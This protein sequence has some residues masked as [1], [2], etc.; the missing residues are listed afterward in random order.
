VLLERAL[1]RWLTAHGVASSARVSRMGLRGLRLDGVSLGAADAPDFTADRIQVRWSLW[2]VFGRRATQVTGTGVR[3]RARLRDGR[4]SLGALD[5]LLEPGG[6]AGAREATPPFDS[7]ALRDVHVEVW[8]ASGIVTASGTVA[9]DTRHGIPRARVDLAAETPWIAGRALGRAAYERSS[10]GR[11]VVRWHGRMLAPTFEV[12][13]HAIATGARASVG[14][15]DG[16][17]RAR[18][19]APE[20]LSLWSPPAVGPMLV[21]GT[22]VGT[23]ERLLVDA[24]ATVKGT[25]A[26]VGPGG[27]A[28]VRGTMNLAGGTLGGEV[29]VAAKDVDLTT[30]GA[31]VRRVSGV[32]TVRLG[33]TLSTPAGQTLAMAGVETV[34]PLGGGLVVFQLTRDAAVV[35]ERGEWAFSGGTLRARGRLPL[36]ARERAIGITADGIDLGTLLASLSL[37]GLSGT[38]KVSGELPLRQ[39]G[40]RLLVENGRLAATS[41]GTLRYQAQPGTEAMRK[42]H[43]ELDVLLTALEDFHYDALSVTVSGDTAGPMA[44]ALHVRGRNPRYEAGRDVVLNVN[45]EAPLA[46]LV[47]TGA[48][49]YRVPEAIEK[50]LDAMGLGGRR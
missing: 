34:L 3:L 33:R 28:R 30:A 11:H 7:V 4:L 31:V 6:D 15:R 5:R 23:L 46:G 49:A 9:A 1:G 25:D 19:V 8:T 45:V 40:G 12:P 13:G 14:G 18:F 36:A 22:A 21:S 38:G 47:R 41:P 37:E 50:K 44:M 27:T 48:S 35:V 24:T 43:H 10:D 39:A 2:S 16:A 32:V 17:L 20:V 26:A 29:T 42:R